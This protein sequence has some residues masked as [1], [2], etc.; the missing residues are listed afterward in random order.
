MGSG[1]REERANRD[2]LFT[3]EGTRMGRREK[4]GTRKRK[5]SK[6]EAKEMLRAIQDWLPVSHASD[7]QDLQRD[8]KLTAHGNKLSG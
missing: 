1:A 2:G 7:Q 3:G 5:E 8:R 6:S 4:S